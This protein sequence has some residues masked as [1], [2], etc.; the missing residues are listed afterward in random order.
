MLADPTLLRSLVDYVSHDG[1]L[2]VKMELGVATRMTSAMAVPRSMRNLAGP[3][4]A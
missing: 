4:T 2:P 1:I 3:V